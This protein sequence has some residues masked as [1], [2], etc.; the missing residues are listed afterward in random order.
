MPPWQLLA[1]IQRLPEGS[2]YMSKL[3]DAEF[4]RAFLGASAESYALA[5]IVDAV[6]ANTRA[7]GNWRK[8]PP[9]IDP[10]PTPDAVAKAARKRE[11]A[12]PKSVAALFGAVQASLGGRPGVK[13]H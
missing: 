3:R 4:W 2:M 5:A 12:K 6:N 9:K 11:E 13:T 10:Y 8:S 1:Y 7:T